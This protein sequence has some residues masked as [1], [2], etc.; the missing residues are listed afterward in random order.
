VIWSFLLIWLIRSPFFWPAQIINKNPRIRTM[1][2]ILSEG[3]NAQLGARP[4]V[5]T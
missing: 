5:L 2:R 1:N 4:L 3:W